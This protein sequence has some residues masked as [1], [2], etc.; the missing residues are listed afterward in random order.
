MTRAIASRYQPVLVVLHWLVAVMILGLLCVGFFVL[1]NMPN[2]D[3]KKLDILVLHMSG[4]MFVLL[5]MI[6]RVIVRMRSARPAMATTGSPALDRLA[7][8]T[9]RV[10][11]AIIFL[12]IA[13]GWLTGYVISGVFANQGE[14]LPASFAVLPTFQV[15][16][17]LAILL[18]LLIAGH[19]V[20]ALYH[21]FVLKDGLF[22]RMW[23]GKRT[24]VPP[25]K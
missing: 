10:L 4:G 3:P 14:H 19:V 22:R 21:Q 9:H 11:Y 7:S 2:S 15:H 20:A 5:L 18:T 16:A 1:A 24:I 13:S 8:T 25:E 12:M 23:F 17:T 6:V